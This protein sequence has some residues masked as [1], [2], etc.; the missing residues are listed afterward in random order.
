[1]NQGVFSKVKINFLLVGHTHYHIDVMFNT[2]SRKLSRY[3][4]FTLPT[5]LDIIC[6]AYIPR[7]NVQHVKEIYDF[8]RYISHGGERNAKVLAPLNNINVNHVFL[9]KKINLSDCTFLYV[10]RYSSSP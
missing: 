6:D 1:M 4:A 9:I 7:P 5:L 3:D 8:K 10:K 2:F